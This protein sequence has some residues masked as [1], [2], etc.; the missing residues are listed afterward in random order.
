MPR[1]DVLWRRLQS[2]RPAELCKLGEIL[3]ISE[4]NAKSRDVI[5]EE[6]SRE[7]RCAA[8][9]SIPNLF[10]SPHDFPYKQMLIDVADKMAPGFTFLSWTHYKLHDV[11]GEIEIEETIWGFFENLVKRAIGKLSPEAKEDLR[12]K[13]EEELRKMGYGEAVI[14]QIGAAILGGSA[15][16]LIGP[17]LAYYVALNTASGLMWLKI[18]LAGKAALAFVL[19]T[20][21]AVFAVIYLPIIAYWFGNTAYRKTVPATLHLIQIRKLRELENQLGQVGN[22]QE[23]T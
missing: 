19:G 1:D 20:G 11:H 17:A 5:I 21:S 10:R 9:H 3:K 12:K 7:I 15:A 14:T 18:W 22:A 13:T 2:A 6:L 4:L 16:I 23:L 8:G